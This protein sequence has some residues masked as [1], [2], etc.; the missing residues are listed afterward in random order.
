MWRDRLEDKQTPLLEP[1]WAAGRNRRAC[2]HGGGTHC[3]Q[4]AE[5][6]PSRTFAIPSA[7]VGPAVPAQAPLVVRLPVRSESRHTRASRCR[8][9]VPLPL[10]S[11]K[12]LCEVRQG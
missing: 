2:H 10:V 5:S 7:S 9:T 3:C 8:T 12:V 11:G 1:Q 6:D 4:W